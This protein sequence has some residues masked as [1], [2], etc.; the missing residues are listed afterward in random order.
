[1]SQNFTDNCFAGTHIAQ[2]DM[3]NIEN[4][5][6]CLKSNFAGSAAPSNPTPGMPW[7]DIDTNQT[8]VRNK[9]NN[10]WLSNDF[11][12]GTIIIF[13]QA[14]SPIGWTKVTSWSD[15]SMLCINSQAN[16]TALAAAGSDN[17]PGGATHGAG[18]P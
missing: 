11:V 1:M 13:G 7:F 10:Q 4:N 18:A 15:N 2:T 16:G 14:S 5:L 8:Y 17:P 6:L 12:P 9:D 3:Q